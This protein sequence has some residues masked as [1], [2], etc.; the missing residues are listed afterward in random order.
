MRK[1]TLKR[2]AWIKM[3]IDLLDYE[4]VAELFAQKGAVGLGVYLSLI[5]LIYR[6]EEKR[7]SLAQAINFRIKGVQK[8]P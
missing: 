2:I 6:R 8:P 3:P 4:P 1:N 5:H 7:I